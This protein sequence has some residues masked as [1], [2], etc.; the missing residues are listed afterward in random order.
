MGK[1]S[2]RRWFRV[3]LALYLWAFV[4]YQI[5]PVRV[6]PYVN[7]APKSLHPTPLIYT[8]SFAYNVKTAFSNHAGSIKNLLQAMDDKNIDIAFGDFP[9]GIEDRLFPTPKESDCYMVRSSSLPLIESLPY[10]LFEVI[11]KLLVLEKPSDPAG[12]MVLNRSHK[13]YLALHDDKVLISTFFGLD[14][15]SYSYILGNKRNLYFSRDLL[16]REAYLQDFLKG[17]VVVMGEGD[18]KVF[19]YSDRS[20]YLPGDETV[21]N[22]RLVVNAN[23]PNPVIDLFKDGEK[24][25]VFTQDRLNFPIKEKGR[26]TVHV[27]SYKFKIHIFYFGVRSVALASSITLM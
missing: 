17:A 2:I 14:I 18:V 5:L 8:Y 11:P 20:F 25:A 10:L 3:G 27:M 9:E 21:Y 13:C 19:G 22:F 16:I 6:I 24:I 23:V 7:Y 26:Y 1:R 12:R 4:L 15:P